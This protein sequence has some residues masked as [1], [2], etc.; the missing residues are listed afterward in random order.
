MSPIYVNIPVSLGKAPPIPK[1][2]DI[3]IRKLSNDWCEYID[4]ETARKYYFHSSS[5]KVT[6]KPPRRRENLQVHTVFIQLYL[7]LLI[8]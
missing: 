4:D 6:W 3:P 7:H 2:S 5:G 8:H 1:A